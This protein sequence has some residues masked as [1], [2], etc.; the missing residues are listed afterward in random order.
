MKILFLAKF[1]AQSGC[2]KWA[3]L[4]EEEYQKNIPKKKKKRTVWEF[5]NLSKINHKRL[6]SD[7]TAQNRRLAG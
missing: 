4:Q 5:K 6:E 3:I 7:T 1:L 2:Q